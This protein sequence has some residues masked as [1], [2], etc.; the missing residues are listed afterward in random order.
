MSKN[1][2]N[3]SSAEQANSRFQ[4]KLG[5]QSVPLK[6]Q[7]LVSATDLAWVVNFHELNTLQSL[8]FL[9]LVR[10]IPYLPHYK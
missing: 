10:I 4:I 7:C 8:R 5:E 6:S 1:F 9:V 2:V 3:V